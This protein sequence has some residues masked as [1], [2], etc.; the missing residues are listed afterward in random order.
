MPVIV[1]GSRG[2]V[3]IDPT[4][5]DG[6]VIQLL[7]P[8]VPVIGAFHIVDQF[9]T[10]TSTTVSVGI[11]SSATLIGGAEETLSPLIVHPDAVFSVGVIS[12]LTPFVTPNLPPVVPAPITPSTADGGPTV[13]DFTDS[14]IVVFDGAVV[15]FGGLSTGVTSDL[16]PIIP[17]PV[18]AGSST[19]TQG[20]VVG[21]VSPPPDL[22][23]IVPAGQENS[24]TAPIITIV[25]PQIVS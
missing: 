5:D 9:M 3:P 13:D 7:D 18:N 14:G 2:S 22:D 15:Y 25:N 21:G 6:G 12:T 20:D 19:F 23:P 4:F 10:I 16:D 24:M 1:L 11:T 8:D 17:P